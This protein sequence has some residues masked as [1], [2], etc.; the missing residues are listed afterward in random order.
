MKNW[1]LKN[2]ERSIFE[3]TGLIPR[4]IL[5]IFENFKNQLD[6]N[7]EQNVLEQLRVSRYQALASLRYIFIL[8]ITPL[9][10]NLF[11]TIFIF[12]PLINY[13]W[14]KQK[15]IFFPAFFLNFILVY[16]NFL[17][18]KKAG[19][20]FFFLFFFCE[21]PM[22]TLTSFIPLQPAHAP[23]CPMPPINTTRTYNTEMSQ[24]WYSIR[25]EEAE[26]K[27]ITS[28]A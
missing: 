11:S 21:H 26:E 25:V 24:S 12:G 20:F 10:I 27:T 28:T 14:K 22:L 1:E 16:L 6:P 13:F 8:I 18:K 23:R 15:K 19:N 4:S 7:R 2:I 17:K 3:K 5:R 9:F